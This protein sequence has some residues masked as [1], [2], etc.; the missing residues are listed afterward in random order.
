MDILHNGFTLKIPNG[1]FPLSTDSI[2]L[3]D[4]VRLPKNSNVLDMCSGCGTLGLLLCAKDTTCHITGIEID[5][6]SHE[7]ALTNI[8]DNRISARLTS[9]CDDI[10][11]YRAFLAP[12]SFHICVSNPPYFVAGPKSKETPTARREDFCNAETLFQCAAWAL[13][14]GGD[15]YLVHRPERLAQLCALGARFDLE[16]K[17]LSCLRHSIDAPVS[18]VLIQFRKGGKPG[19]VWEETVLHN[20]D[21]SPTSDYK[22]IY[23]LQEE[24]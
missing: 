6:L 3:A 5:P 8:A 13:R 4:F 10:G 1:S 20:Q 11:N 17:R 22:R 9:I 2:V 12:G 7:G 15:F 18:L 14:Y 23:H 24:L 19:L 16:A 21:G